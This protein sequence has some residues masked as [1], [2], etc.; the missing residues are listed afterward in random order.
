MAIYEIWDAIDRRVSHTVFNGLARLGLPEI[1]K[2]P[3]L[4][5]RACHSSTAPHHKFS[6]Q[7]RTSLLC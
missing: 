3:S 4:S 1:L 5:Q 2:G 7:Q 6:A